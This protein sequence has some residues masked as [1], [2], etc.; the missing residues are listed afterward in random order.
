MQPLI[1]RNLWQ[2]IED[3]RA[4]FEPP[5]GNKV[6]WEDS[7]FTAMI[8]RGPNARRDFHVDPSD[9]IFYMLKGDMALEYIDGD[10]AR[11][12]A[13]IREGDLLLTPGNVPHSPHRPADTWGLVIE[14]KRGPQ[15]HESLIWYCEQCTAELHRVTMSA[16]DIEAGLKA[17][18]LGFDADQGL[19]TCKACGHIQSATTPPYAMAA[20]TVSR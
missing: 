6:I 10:G 2:W 11:Q 19:R 13:I 16:L 12:T 7:Q 20:A 15:D 5:V 4:S 17:A 14:R 9:E 8:I 18:L 3:N 1:A